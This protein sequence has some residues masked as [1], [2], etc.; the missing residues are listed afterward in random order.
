MNLV[1]C[2]CIY[3][4]KIYNGRRESSLKVS[5]KPPQHMET[6]CFVTSEWLWVLLGRTT[7]GLL[8]RKWVKKHMLGGNCR[9]VTSLNH[10]ILSWAINTQQSHPG[11]LFM[12]NVLHWL[13]Q[14]L[15]SS[16]VFHGK[17]FSGIDFMHGEPTHH[18]R[19][20]EVRLSTSR[21]DGGS[22]GKVLDKHRLCQLSLFRHEDVCLLAAL[23]AFWP[24]CWPSCWPRPELVSYSLIGKKLTSNIFKWWL[25]FN[26][27]DFYD[28]FF[29]TGVHKSKKSN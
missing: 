8:H 26:W 12:Q 2:F 25:D 28:I 14:W 6:L 5:I 11:L 23:S 4:Q 27:L 29:C 19:E 3:C 10:N 18:S 21:Q 1:M 20:L 15:T 24:S 7:V 16:T 17:C 13:T 9:N 22:I